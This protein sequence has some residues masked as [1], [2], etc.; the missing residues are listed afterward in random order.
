M[1]SEDEKP[2]PE[3]RTIFIPSP[4]SQPPTPPPPQVAPPP[5][6]LTPETPGPETPPPVTSAPVPPDLA[7]EAP[8]TTSPAAEPPAAPDPQQTVTSPG[9]SAP[10]HGVTTPGVG[11]HAGSSPGSSW[12]GAAPLQPGEEGRRIQIGDVLNHIFEVRRFIGRGGMGEVFEGVNINTEER[13]AIKAI[14][15]HL[16]ADPAVQ[17]MF[18]KEARTLTRLSHPGLVQYRV[19]AMEPQLRALYIVTEFID[20]PNLSDNLATLNPSPEQM[21]ALLGKLAEG[22]AAAHALGAIHRDIS[23]D[24]VMLEGGQ[25][26][27]AKVIDFGIAKDL[28]AAG[29]T[30]VGDGFAGKLNYVAPEQLGDFD[31]EVGPWT[32]VYSLG[33]TM[34]AVVLGRDVNMG[35]TLVDAVD[36]RRAGLDVGSAPE[37][38]RPVLEL[39]LRANPAERLRSMTDVLHMLGATGSA[40]G[41]GSLTPR[42]EFGGGLHGGGH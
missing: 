16:A 26:E 32:D 19:L 30:I 42:T 23:P 35:A 10:G 6:T 31:R 27:R 4:G 38:M 7:P 37:A 15:P 2:L 33:L 3:D 28:D 17:A 20:G 5:E 40:T 9:L 18:R 29:S 24:N 21:V 11:A 41:F 1:S 39:M 12:S 34:M 25:I 22:L 36:K 14:L 13:V 8:S